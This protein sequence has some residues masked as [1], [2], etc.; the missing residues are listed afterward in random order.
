MC[1]FALED[2]QPVT[3]I[4]IKYAGE[5]GQEFKEWF[6]SRDIEYKAG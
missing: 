6:E 1:Y 3:E 2:I 5:P 4:C